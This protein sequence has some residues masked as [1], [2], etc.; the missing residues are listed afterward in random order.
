MLSGLGLEVNYTKLTKGPFTSAPKSAILAKLAI[1]K[2]RRFSQNWR[3][4]WTKK[5]AILAKILPKLAISKSGFW[6]DFA[7]IGDFN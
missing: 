3:L 4:L 2:N 1:S 7:E 5:Q 6:L